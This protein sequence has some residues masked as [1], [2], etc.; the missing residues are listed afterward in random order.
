MRERKEVLKIFA[1]LRYFIK[2][3][4]LFA[5]EAVCYIQ[6]TTLFPI[7]P[8]ISNLKNIPLLPAASPTRILKVEF[9]IISVKQKTKFSY[10]RYIL[11]LLTASLSL[12]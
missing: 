12:A 7:P 3:C 9:L 5:L 1:T 4:V 2:M 6:R 11:T 10:F 8:P